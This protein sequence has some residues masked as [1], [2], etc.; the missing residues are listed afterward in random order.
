MVIK[1]GRFRYF[2]LQNHYPRFGSMKYS[3]L[4]VYLKNYPEIKVN[5]LVL[6]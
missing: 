3:F 2:F 4:Y 5:F 1:Q 6:C